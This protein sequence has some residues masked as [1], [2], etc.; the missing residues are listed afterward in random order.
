MVADMPHD[1]PD[2]P[3][4]L[5]ATHYSTPGYVM[6]W[7]LRAAPAHMLRLQS[8]RFDA[9]D[10]LFASIPEAWK[11]RRSQGWRLAYDLEVAL[12]A[13]LPAPA[14]GSHQYLPWLYKKRAF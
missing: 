14:V 10:R 2:D 7:T 9:P 3:P 12:T 13:Q 11:V 1:D 8:G 6:F 5:Y 4:F